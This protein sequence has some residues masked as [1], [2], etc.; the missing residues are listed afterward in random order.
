MLKDLK[1]QSRLIEL[2]TRINA[3]ENIRGINYRLMKRG[4]D[5][6]TQAEQA[7]AVWHASYASIHRP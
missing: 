1:F 3:T 2:C 5:M 7:R 4:I 6:V